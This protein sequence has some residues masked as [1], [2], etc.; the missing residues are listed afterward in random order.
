MFCF[1]LPVFRSCLCNQP[2][3]FDLS[4]ISFHCR[5]LLFPCQVFFNDKTGGYNIRTC[6]GHLIFPKKKKKKKI[7]MIFCNFS[8]TFTT[9]YIRQIILPWQSPGASSAMLQS[10]CACMYMKD[11]LLLIFY[12]VVR[13]L[14]CH[15][16]N[17]NSTIF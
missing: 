10:T 6:S 14:N 11:F 16:L 12:L 17:P 15:V 8:L 9:I 5:L 1:V 3:E 7:I 4:V 13:C 2:N